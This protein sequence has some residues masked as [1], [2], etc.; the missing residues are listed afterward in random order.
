MFFRAQ[1]LPPAEFRGFTAR[2]GKPVEYPFVHGLAGFTKI[3]Q[4]LKRE[5]ERTNFG[6]IWHRDTSYLDE[7]PM[8]S[9]LLACELPPYGGDTLFANQ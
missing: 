5:D 1:P 4:V 7:P 2:F 3:I 6:G 9:M 8:G